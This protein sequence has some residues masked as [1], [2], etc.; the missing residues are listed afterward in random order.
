MTTSPE[1]NA[2]GLFASN[3]GEFARRLPQALTTQRPRAECFDDG[4]QGCLG[5]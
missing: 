2:F 3:T 1:I 4:R 5:A